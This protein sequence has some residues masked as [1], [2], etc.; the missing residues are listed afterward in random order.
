MTIRGLESSAR[1][2]LDQK[3]D[4][5]PLGKNWH[6]NFLARRLDLKKLRSQA[7]D[8]SRTDATNYDTERQWS[9]L[10]RTIRLLYD[11]NDENIYN[12]DE[13]GCMKRGECKGSCPT[14]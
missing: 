11:I 2:L 7:L 13:K 4:H 12:M 9:D 5:I 10:F 1:Q 6:D 8:Q 14:L 3:G